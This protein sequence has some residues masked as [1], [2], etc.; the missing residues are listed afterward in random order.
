M[1]VGD[2]PP[3]IKKLID[4]TRQSLYL[5]IEKAMRPGKKL[6]HIAYVI[7]DYVT[8]NG[9][10]V[11]QDYGG[12]GVGKQLH[13]PPFIPNKV[14]MDLSLVLKEGMVLA[15]EPM[16]TPGSGHTK[17]RRDQWTVVTRENKPAAHFEHTVAITAD[18]YEVLTPWD[19]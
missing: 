17:V 11:I 14:I 18:G 16:V 3:K 1:A 2:V 13:E 5:A 4:V 8:S 6:F 19:R 15:L 12:H 7:E 10:N 9:F